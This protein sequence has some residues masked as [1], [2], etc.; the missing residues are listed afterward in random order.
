MHNDNLIDKIKDIELSNKLEELQKIN[1]SLAEVIELII[2]I[3]M[4][5]GHDYTHSN[6]PFSNFKGVAASTNQ[7]VD[8]V[9]ETMI[10]VKTE[11]IKALNINNS[12]PMNESLWDSKL[13]RAVYCLLQCAYCAS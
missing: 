6:D 5:K 13:D 3:H 12:E 11:R 9:F 10:A 2:D 4:K 8:S 1:P 7:S